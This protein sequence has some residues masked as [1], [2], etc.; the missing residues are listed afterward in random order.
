MRPKDEGCGGAHDGSE[1][2]GLG[3]F[4][5]SLLSGLPWHERAEANETLQLASPSGGAIRVDNA[6]GCTVVVGEDRADV[7][8]RVHKAARGGSEAEAT[9]LASSIKV[10]ARE[11]AAGVL[12]VEVSLPGRWTH[13]GRAD[14]EIHAPRAVRVQV[15]ASNGRVCLSGM[16][17]AVRLHSSN[18]PVRVE[19]V[20]GDIEIHTSNARVHTHCTCGKLVA[21][22]SNGKID[23]EE[24]RGSVD[25][26]TSNGTIHCDVDHL[27]KEGVVLVTSNGRISL[28]LPDEVDGDV[29][30]RV[31]NGLI[32][33]VRDFRHSARETA[34]RLK[35][36]LGRGGVP[37]R[38]RASNGTISLR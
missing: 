28:E 17:A 10:L 29:D 5:R 14:L 36:T 23:L 11:D 20:V 12:D 26:A 38:L 15:T 24:H 2:R 6:N 7:E 25:A 9:Q 8:I 4:L 3:G 22:S 1:G 37:I 21:R 27:G 18:G 16:R 13:R 31:D 33:A 19:D 34:G 32:R 30:I 35:G